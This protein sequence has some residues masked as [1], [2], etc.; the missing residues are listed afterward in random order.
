MT[1][2]Q[3]TGSVKVTGN[4]DG[5]SASGSSSSGSGGSTTATG[6]KS[7]GSGTGTGAG[8]AGHGSGTAATSDRCAT[9]N[10]RLH[11]EQGDAGAGQIHYTLVLTNQGTSS[12]TMNGFPG[13]SVMRRDGSTVGKPAT[14]SGGQTGAVRLAPGASAH[15]VLHT[16]NQGMSDAGCWTSGQ[17]LKVYPPNNTAPATVAAPNG[18]FQVCGDTFDTTTVQSGAAA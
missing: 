6:A 18:S 14:R 10:L 13:V 1:A 15:V 17:L 2:C 3:G 8:G 5:S 12:C 7:D 4:G 11:L 16:I 9:D